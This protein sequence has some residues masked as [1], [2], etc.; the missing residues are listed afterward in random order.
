MASGSRRSGRRDGPGGTFRELTAAQALRL[1][2]TRRAVRLLD[3]AIPIPGTRQRIGLDPIL[4]LV[5]GVGDV[6]PALFTVAVLWQAHQLGIPRVVLARM[7]MN[8]ALDTLIGLVPMLGDLFDVAWK[9]N[10]RNLALLEAHAYEVRAA[11]FGDRV[12]VGGLM[13]AVVAVAAA[14]FLVL[15]WLIGAASR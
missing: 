7:L 6:L 12:F 15:W 5:P 10:T 9:S 1:E 8:T 11:T 13:C 4:G 3:S 14:P 2:A